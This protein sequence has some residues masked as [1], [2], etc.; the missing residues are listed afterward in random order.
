ML[1][2]PLTA[3]TV[4]VAAFSRGGSVVPR[5]EA[6]FGPICHHRPE[7]TLVVH[8]RPLSVCARC[9]GLWIGAGLGGLVGLAV[10]P[11]PRTARIALGVAVVTGGVGLAAGI[12]EALG[13]FATANPIRAGLGA[14]LG[15]GPTFAAGVSASVLLRAA[16]AAPT[17][18]R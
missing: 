15:F 1:A 9:T 13:I 12:A 16:A 2:G 8:G 17:A 5:I 4:E 11:R 7:R 14:I 3:T 6:A 18:P 10:P